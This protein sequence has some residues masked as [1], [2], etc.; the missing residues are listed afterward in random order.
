MTDII[1]YE[2]AA[3]VATA[4]C[5]ADRNPALV[6][7]LSLAESSRRPMAQS[8]NIIAA[9]LGIGKTFDDNGKEDTYR[10]VPWGALCYSK[11]E[12]G[13]TERHNLTTIIRTRLGEGYSASIANLS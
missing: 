3:I 13:K 8:L 2:P 4:A 11:I 1:K 9:L 7:L 5:A 10:F 12:D 6:Y